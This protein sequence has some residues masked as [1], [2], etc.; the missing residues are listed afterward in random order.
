AYITDKRSTD[1]EA[2]THWVFLAYRK[3]SLRLL[4]AD[5]GPFS[6]QA[7]DG[8]SDSHITDEET[9]ALRG[10]DLLKAFWLGHKSQIQ[11]I[12]GDPGEE[13]SPT[14]GHPERVTY[15]RP[16][17]EPR[18]CLRNNNKLRTN[19]LDSPKWVVRTSVLTTPKTGKA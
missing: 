16:M 2:P 19:V 7:R 17:A 12:A 13:S 8:V 10:R 4:G 6:P 9:K 5:I 1:T 15:P 3:I 18:T 11:S 14:Q